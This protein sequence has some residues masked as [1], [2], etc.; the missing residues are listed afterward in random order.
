MISYLNFLRMMYDMISLKFVSYH[1]YDIIM[2]KKLKN[3]SYIRSIIRIFVH[4]YE[5]GQQNF[6]ETC[7]TDLFRQIT[8]FSTGSSASITPPFSSEADDVQRVQ[9]ARKEG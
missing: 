2:I 3:L 1:T 9:L 4:I 6:V 8:G 7:K 5:P